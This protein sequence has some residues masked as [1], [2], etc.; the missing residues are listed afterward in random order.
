M[1]VFNVDVTT[2]VQLG[3]DAG[4]RVSVSAV[5]CDAKVDSVDVQ[6]QGHFRCRQLADDGEAQQRS[7]GQIVTLTCL[8][9]LR[10]KAGYTGRR[11]STTWRTSGPK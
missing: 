1:A 6:L 8:L 5:H 9:F 11:C 3:E 7:L 10:S 4:G 2:V